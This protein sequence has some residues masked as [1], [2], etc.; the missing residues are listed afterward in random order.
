[1][2]CGVSAASIKGCSLMAQTSD[3]ASEW[4][5]GIKVAALRARPPC[6][7]VCPCP[8]TDIQPLM[9]LGGS[10][11]ELKQKP[12]KKGKGKEAKHNKKIR[13]DKNERD[14]HKQAKR[15]VVLLFRVSSLLSLCLENPPLSEGITLSG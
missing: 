7:I 15:Q 6:V 14:E 8:Q 5:H 9:K 4:I 13:G 1:M 10:I 11:P 12:I 3:A 2:S